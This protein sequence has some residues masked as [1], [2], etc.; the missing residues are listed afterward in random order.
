M[1]NNST[2]DYN[3]LY[4]NDGELIGD[5]NVVGDLYKFCVCVIHILVTTYTVPAGVLMMTM[6]QLPNMIM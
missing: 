2:V 6:I 3:P 1:N 5:I 4:N